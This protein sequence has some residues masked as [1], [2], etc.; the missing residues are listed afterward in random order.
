MDDSDYFRSV[1][2]DAL[3]ARTR[4][5][6]ICA[7]LADVEDDLAVTL[8]RLAAAAAARGRRDTADELHSSAE[9]AR[10]SAVRARQH[11]CGSD[12]GTQADEPV[13]APGLGEDDGRA[14]ATSWAAT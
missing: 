3:A 5:R 10:R 4:A 7:V 14:E 2:A 12:A 9:H 13:D 8:D 6:M 1:R 11:A